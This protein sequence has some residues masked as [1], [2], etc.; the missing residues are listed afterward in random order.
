MP[1]TRTSF[2]LATVM[3]L[4]GCTSYLPIY[5]QPELPVEEVIDGSTSDHALSNETSKTKVQ[6]VSLKAWQ[7]FFP[8]QQLQT[9]IKQALEHNSDLHI[10]TANVAEAEGMFQIQRNEQIPTIST[11]G[12]A[13]ISG[14]SKNLTGNTDISRNYSA[15][16]GWASYEIDFW[17]RV[18]SLKA[19][20]LASYFATIA[21]QRSS[22][23]TVI[24]STATSYLNW[25][26]AKQKLNLAQ[27]TLQTRIDSYELIKL[28]ES[29]GV[30]SNLDL[31]QAEVA[32]A[33]V[34][35]QRAQLIRAVIEARASLELLVGQPISKV[36]AQSD[37]DTPLLLEFTTPDKLSAQLILARPDIINA[38]ETLRSSNANIGAARAAFL[39]RIALTANAGFASNSLSKLFTSDAS[40][41]SIAPAISFPIFGGNNKANLKVA[42]ARNDKALAQ[43]QKAIKSAF[44]EI[45]IELKS[46]PSRDIEIAANKRLVNAQTTRLTLAQERY[47]AG[48]S[49]YIEVLDSQQNLF[50]AQQSLLDSE[51][52][53]AQST[54]Q[55][56]RSLGGGD[57]LNS[58]FRQRDSALKRNTKIA[59]SN[60]I[61][62]LPETQVKNTKSESIEVIAP[63][64]EKPEL[65]EPKTEPPKELQNKTS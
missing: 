54:I 29:I 36:L 25:L 63:D 41:W 28:K 4:S 12:G 5:K 17:G 26:T 9:L 1:F 56:Y 2:A 64:L 11:N 39:P 44:S 59:K 38:E 42:K 52:A 16:V 43:Y 49:S 45:Y 32:L 3:T 57:G 55:L 51:R 40:T 22:K 13:N 8:D 33:S 50:N 60:N 27:R 18:S 6:T 62:T 20:A 31:A 14:N 19:S 58:S 46:R 48:L 37:L 34:E 21:A 35:A 10:A 65:E 15:N 53:K 24:S 61:K 30:A 7:D 23:L 47:N